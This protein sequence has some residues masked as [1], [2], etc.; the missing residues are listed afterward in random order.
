MKLRLASRAGC[1]VLLGWIAAAPDTSALAAAAQTRHHYDI[2]GG[3]TPSAEMQNGTSASNHF[4]ATP[5][6]VSLA[7]N[8]FELSARLVTAPDACYGDTIFRDGFDP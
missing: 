5:S 8:G 6:P 7:G 1:A 3:L 2:S 4:G